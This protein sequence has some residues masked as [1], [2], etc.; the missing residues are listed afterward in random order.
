MLIYQGWELLKVK[1]DE[2]YIKLPLCQVSILKHYK[3]YQN[4]NIFKFFRKIIY[5]KMWYT[6]P[7]IPGGRST[8]QTHTQT[9]THT[10]THTH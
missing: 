7:Y 1:K 10:D 4:N 9:H 8:K 6:I 5:Y 3:V 2:M